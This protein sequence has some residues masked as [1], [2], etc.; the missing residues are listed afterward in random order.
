VS[1]EDRLAQ[2]RRQLE[3]L[4]EAP[5]SSHPEVLEDVHRALVQKL[6]ALS[7]MDVAAP[8]G[9]TGHANDP[10]TAPQRGADAAE[11]PAFQP[12]VSADAPQPEA[13]QAGDASG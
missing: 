13:D 7:D 2:L 3:A 4:E 5:L 12:P 8:D 10:G 9:E 11:P 1:D 6:E